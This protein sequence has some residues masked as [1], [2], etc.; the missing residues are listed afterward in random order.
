MFMFINF[1]SFSNILE[2][3]IIMIL[4]YLT[5][6]KNTP[7]YNLE[8]L[9]KL[10]RKPECRQI[11]QRDRREA[12]RLGYADDEE[13]VDRVLKLRSDEFRKTMQSK[14]HFTDSKQDVYKTRDGERILYIK[15]S[16]S[17]NGK[18]I[19]VSFKEA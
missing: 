4:F 12:V 5:T 2:K 10:L 3:S 15:L 16:K 7:T 18:A 17:F 13:M 8:E 6:M 9:K 1:L 14:Y 11:M 19:I